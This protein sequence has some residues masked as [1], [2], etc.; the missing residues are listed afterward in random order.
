MCSMRNYLP[1]EECFTI[2]NLDI[3]SDGIS[4]L[5][6]GNLSWTGKW[7]ESEE[8]QLCNLEE[9]KI[10]P[11]P[12]AGVKI[13]LY[14]NTTPTVCITKSFE[15]DQWENWVSKGIPTKPIEVT[16]FDCKSVA[17]AGYPV[18]RAPDAQVLPGYGDP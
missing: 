10:P 6:T 17:I 18:H 7:S 12:T 3:P 11:G 15:E 8:G 14:T 5:F 1:A 4:E 9:D 2:S 13:E 16:K